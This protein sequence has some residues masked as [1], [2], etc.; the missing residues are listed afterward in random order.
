MLAGEDVLPWLFTIAVACKQEFYRR[1]M[2]WGIK[3]LP[4]QHPC[5]HFRMAYRYQRIRMIA[6]V[7]RFSTASGFLAA[8]FE[9][10]LSS[11][12]RSVHRLWAGVAAGDQDAAPAFAVSAAGAG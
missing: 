9:P 5:P 12:P 2:L 4:K 10:E 6:T 3:L 11:A 8:P 1:I 7:E